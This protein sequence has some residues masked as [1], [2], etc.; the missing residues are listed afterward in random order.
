MNNVFAIDAVP[1][2]F[3]HTAPPCAA[4]VI[5]DQACLVQRQARIARHVDRA[6]AAAL[7]VRQRDLR[8]VRCRAR[9]HVEVSC[10]CVRIQ[11]HLVAAVDRHVR[12][13]RLGA[14][15][16]DR[17]RQ[18][19]AVKANLLGRGQGAVESR[20]GAAGG[21]AVA[22][23]DA[24][25][26]QGAESL[27]SPVVRLAV[28]ADEAQAPVIQRIRLQN[29]R[30]PIGPDLPARA[31]IARWDD[32][33][34]IGEQAVAGGRAQIEIA[35]AAN[36]VVVQIADRVSRVD[37]DRNRRGRRVENGG[38]AAEHV[39]ALLRMQPRAAVAV[40]RP[41]VCLQAWRWSA[42]CSIGP[43]LEFPE[44][45]LAGSATNWRA[46]CRP[47]ESNTRRGYN[48]R[49]WQG[50][51]AF[52]GRERDVIVIA[53]HLVR[54]IDRQR[55]VGGQRQIDVSALTAARIAH[56]GDNDV[57]VVNGVGRRL[58][59]FGIGVEAGVGADA[60]LLI[61]QALND[62]DAVGDGGILD[63]PVVPLKRCRREWAARI[64][65]GSG[66][67][68]RAHRQRQSDQQRDQNQRTKMRN[69]NS[70]LVL[71]ESVAVFGLAADLIQEGKQTVQI[72]KAV[73][74]AG[75]RI[76]Q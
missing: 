38:R 23:R 70:P 40:Q 76:F 33:R 48:W 73:P 5:A 69:M 21:R 51:W 25:I 65:C 9:L 35:V 64:G 11:R 16:R 12:T 13:D 55:R 44:C 74:F 67:G 37:R 14:A 24:A 41:D 72:G 43:G 26:R 63:Q 30:G 56:P 68:L 54:A 52:V 2:V 19:A 66:R 45:A 39:H 27:I 17:D 18:R 4:A 3:T 15:Q 36:A 75:A 22:H 20:L 32:G 1:L 50:L 31:G 7:T 71:V 8:Q 49:S 29:I 6:A 47:T 60:V 61:G 42:R 62:A 57:H 46:H 10:A 28:A 59:G 53:A 58:A 34:P